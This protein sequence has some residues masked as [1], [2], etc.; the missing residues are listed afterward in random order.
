LLS[1]LATSAATYYAASI[2]Q[3]V[4]HRFF[5]HVDRLRPVFESHTAGH[6]GTY[7]NEALLSDSWVPAERH[8]MWYF[9]PLF[10]PMVFAVYL[11]APFAIFAAHVF[12][13]TFAIWWHVFLHQQYHL[14]GS[15]FERFQWFQRK[16]QLH[17]VHH[18]HVRRNYA[19]VEFWLDHL[20]GTLEKPN[21]SSSGRDISAIGADR[22]RST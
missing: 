9:V 17:F 12:G 20:L 3:V 16:Q 22:R 2:V 7:R 6:H 11:V 19:I 5:G 18:R 4:A 8:V 10:A 1:L 21:S 13:L 15:I 14:R